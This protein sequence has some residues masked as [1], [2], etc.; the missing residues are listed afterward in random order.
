MPRRRRSRARRATAGPS[1]SAARGTS[2]SASTATAVLDTASPSRKRRRSASPAR[3]VRAAPGKTAPAATVPT[4]VRIPCKPI[5]DVAGYLAETRKKEAAL[6]RFRDG[7]EVAA[8]RS[9]RIEIRNRYANVLLL[10]AGEASL[11]APPAA[12]QRIWTAVYYSGIERLRG[13]VKAR[14][15][16]AVTR[17]A[18]DELLDEAGAFYA[19]LAHRLTRKFRLDRRRLSPAASAASAGS[20]AATTAAAA[21]A[22]ARCHLHAGDVSRYRQLVRPRSMRVWDGASAAYHAALAAAPGLGAAHN[23]LAVLA[24]YARDPL[25]ALYRYVRALAAPL[26]FPSVTDNIALLLEHSIKRGAAA[27]A[28][29]PAAA[30]G[31]RSGLPPP[32]WRS[33]TAALRFVCVHAAILASPSPTDVPDLAPSLHQRGGLGLGDND[34]AARCTALHLA[35]VCVYTAHAWRAGTAPPFAI[36]LVLHL[37]T[38]FLDAIFTHQCAAAVTGACIVAGWLHA[39]ASRVHALG[40]S[41]ETIAAALHTAVARAAEALA[42][43]RDSERGL[44]SAPGN[45]LEEDIE[46]RGF[47]PWEARL[48]PPLSGSATIADAATGDAAAATRQARLAAALEGFIT[49]APPVVALAA[50]AEL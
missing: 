12:E 36:V 45:V 15:A 29:R 11:A 34:A 5:A 2:T 3:P 18:L 50:D 46:L 7:G 14:P 8:E 9:L 6:A 23:Q 27:A 43:L 31:P 48:D 26:P 30:A 16:C 32:T 10:T 37:L 25:T 17:A 35:V 40:A 28:A 41:D 1:S 22:V 20:A 39:A 38:D 13:A 42:A 47:Q 4:R 49:Q 33:S 19:A 21:A 44:P 24:T